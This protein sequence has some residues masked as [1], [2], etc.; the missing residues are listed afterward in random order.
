MAYYSPHLPLTRDKTNGY[1]LTE[2]LKEVVKQNF[3]MLLLTMPGER[4]MIPEFGAGLYQYLF[5]NVTPELRQKI[6]AR[7]REQTGQYMAFIKIRNLD[8][9]EG[10]DEYGKAISNSL[11][12]TIEY[13]I[14]SLSE[15]DV[16]NLTVSQQNV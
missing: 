16:L 3:K 6:E 9:Q 1:K 12:V 10:S 15:V 4:I 11:F 14:D 8:I 5:E 7:I 2:T 13:F